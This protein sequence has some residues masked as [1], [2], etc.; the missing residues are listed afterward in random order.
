LAVTEDS[1]VQAEAADPVDLEVGSDQVVEALAVLVEWEALAQAEQAL[2]GAGR[3]DKR[4]RRGLVSSQPLF[5]AKFNSQA[6]KT[7]REIRD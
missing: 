1:A 2:E 6:S 3:R 4:C 7:L 5:A